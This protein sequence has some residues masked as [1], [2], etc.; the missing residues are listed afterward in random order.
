MLRV[1]GVRDEE[2]KLDAAGLPADDA[3]IA[4]KA[5]LEDSVDDIMERC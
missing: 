4:L 2:S 1:D 5:Q 3:E